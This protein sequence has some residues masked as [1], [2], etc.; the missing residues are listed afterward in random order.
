[1]ARDRE[2]ALQLKRA[3]NAQ[4][5]GWLLDIDYDFVAATNW[6]LTGGLVAIS[7]VYLLVFFVTVW[8]L[9]SV[10]SPGSGELIITVRPLLDGCFAGVAVAFVRL[11][12]SGVAAQ[13]LSS[14]RLSALR[15]QEIAVPLNSVAGCV[16]LLVVFGILPSESNGAVILGFA[17]F[18]G[19]MGLMGIHSLPFAIA[20]NDPNLP[21]VVEVM[22]A[23]PA[24][25]TLLGGRVRW[26]L[27][28]FAIGLV[29]ATAIS[30]IFSMWPVAALLVVPAHAV[31]AVVVIRCLWEKGAEASMRVAAVAA[32]AFFAAAVSAAVIA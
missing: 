21:K 30:L 4:E 31:I 3:P 7:V 15:Q 20:I 29:D 11:L 26:I 10:A 18:G 14:T 1:M 23:L 22:K 24:D 27:V 6:R 19:L 13:L 2:L 25:M 28:C 5:R 17:L 32:I 9:L 8:T 16:G 12:V